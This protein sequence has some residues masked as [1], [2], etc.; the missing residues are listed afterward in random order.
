[1]KHCSKCNTEK[2]S[3]DFH[4]DRTSADGR[5]SQCRL[6]K[7]AYHREYIRANPRKSAH[8]NLKY[9]LKRNYGITP[10]D[11]ER[12]YERCGLQCEICAHP[13]ARPSPKG[14]VAY[15]ASIDHSHLTGAVRGVLCSN[16]NKALGMLQ[17]DPNVVR[18]A[19][20]YLEKH[21]S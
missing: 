7:T 9:L 2:P 4:V 11:R 16:C 12:L 17:D 19:A 1:M 5:Y 8:N 15:A 6:C 10:K 21:G 18:M 20:A 13:L 14:Q 3:S